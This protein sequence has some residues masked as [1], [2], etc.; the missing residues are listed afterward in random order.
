MQRTKTIT[1]GKRDITVK[2]LNVAQ[3]RDLMDNLEKDKE[4][5]VFDMLFPDSIPVVAVSESTGIALKK[6]EEDF[7]PS[8]LKQIIDG[9]ENL[10]PFFANMMQRMAK[11]GE[12][13][14][15]EKALIPPVAD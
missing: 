15:K 11:I 8:E 12:A 6:L 2:E 5:H 7:T 9:V 3:I 14:L 13:I 10:N 4:V 1:V